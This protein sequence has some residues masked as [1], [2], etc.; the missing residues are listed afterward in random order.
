MIL[1]REVSPDTQKLLTRISQKS[2]N[3]QV[4][5][6]ARCIILRNQGFAVPELVSIFAV[7][8]KTIHNWIKRWE[9]KGIVGLYNEKGRG[10]K[11][12]LNPEQKKQ[13]KEWV[14]AEPKDLKKVVMKVEK[15]WGI[16]VHKETIKRIIKKWK[17]RWK[18][19]KRGI[20]KSPDEWELEVKTPKLLELKEQDKKGEID[21]RYFDETG[22]SLMPCIPYGWQNTG[23]T[24]TLRSSQSK[25]INILGLM[26]CRNELEYQIVEE[27][28]DTEKVIHFLDK[29]S[30]KISKKTVIIL[31]QAS[32]HTSD[33]FL[34][35]LEEWSSRNLNLFWL[36]TY[37]PE[38]N[39]I[40]ILWRFLK[41]EWIETTAYESWK[42]LI[43]YITKVLDYFGEKYVINFV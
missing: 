28:V 18:R 27:K 20:S 6:R 19:M 15:E 12:K 42:S 43:Q 10:S 39:L 21:L 24:I 33:K 22:F 16:S 25:R 11:A 26:N 29:F 30:L 13:V 34:E 36:P 14:E 32:I 2:K 7:T 17:M 37:S 23:E 38:Y 9:M 5:E 4:R 1:L 8:Q 40:E 3:P 31:D 41:Y 35:K